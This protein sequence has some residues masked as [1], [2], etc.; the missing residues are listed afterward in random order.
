[1][2]RVSIIVSYWF[3]TSPVETVILNEEVT[4]VDLGGG[5]LFGVSQT[6][7]C[8]PSLVWCREVY[9]NAEGEKMSRLKPVD[10]DWIIRRLDRWGQKDLLP[11]MGPKVPTDPP[12]ALP[13]EEIREAYGCNLSKGIKNP[14]PKPDLLGTVPV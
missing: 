6:A 9:I 1:M 11:Q 3:G 8:F 14:V 12:P 5:L 13:K 2:R 7:T 4:M 10:D